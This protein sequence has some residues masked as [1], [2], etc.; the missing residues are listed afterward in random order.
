MWSVVGYIDMRWEAP[1]AINTS[2][3]GSAAAMFC[4]ITNEQL[5]LKTVCTQPSLPSNI[6]GSKIP[7]FGPTHECES[8]I[9]SQI[10]QACF[11]NQKL[12]TKRG[13][14]E[15]YRLQS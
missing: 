10:E 12:A 5:V 6:A 1:T 2:T 15:V 8:A 7:M 13:L 4:T 3:I 9:D 14:V 11:G